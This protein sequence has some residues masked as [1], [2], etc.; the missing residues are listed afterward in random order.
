[1][2]V[3]V[4]ARRDPDIYVDATCPQNAWD[5]DGKATKDMCQY[6]GGNFVWN[7]VRVGFIS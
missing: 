5:P 7:N 1:M 6:K 4:T 3:V 2:C